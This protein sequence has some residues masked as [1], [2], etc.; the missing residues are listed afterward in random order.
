MQQP[1]ERPVREQLPSGLAA[2]AVVRLVLGVDDV[3]DGRAAVGAGLAV[4]AVDGHLGTEGGD[5][6][7]EAG[8]RSRRAGGR[9]IR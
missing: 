2:G 7:R 9:S 5:F 6:L 4:A 1:R 8:R 3:L